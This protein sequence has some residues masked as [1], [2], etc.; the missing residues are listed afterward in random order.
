MLINLGTDVHGKNLGWDTSTGTPLTI[1]GP[2]GSGKTMLLDSIIR[3]AD[4]DGT[5]VTFTDQWDSIPPSPTVMCGRYQQPYELLE[6]V[7][8]VSMEQRR[9]IKGEPEPIKPIL[10]AFD[11]Y[12]VH[13]GYPDMNLLN[14]NSQISDELSRIIEMAPGTNVNVVM[15]R[16]SIHPS[17]WVKSSTT[18]LS[19]AT[20]CYS[21]R[22]DSSTRTRNLFSTPKTPV[23]PKPSPISTGIWTS[24]RPAIAC[25][26]HQT[27][28]SRPSTPP[29]TRER[30]TDGRPSKENPSRKILPQWF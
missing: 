12:D 30:K 20:M 5:L 7:Q 22:P 19:P 9:R 21:I 29:S 27:G 14:V 8:R 4:S 26:K 15:V 3:Q 24:N 16:S 6:I 18:G 11:D 28:H 23:K 1:T 2:D 10:L 25:T 13:N 17:K